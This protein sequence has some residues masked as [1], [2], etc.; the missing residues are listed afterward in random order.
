MV[1]IICAMQVA[2][3]TSRILRSA[4]RAGLVIWGWGMGGEILFLG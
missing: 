1:A 3:S 4:W 2:T